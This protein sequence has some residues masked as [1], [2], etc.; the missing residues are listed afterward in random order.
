MGITPRSVSKQIKEMIDGVYSEKSGKDDLKKAHDAAE[1]E[2]MDWDN[3]EAL[4]AQCPLEHRPK[5]R[6]LSEFAQRHDSPVV[7]DPYYGSAK[8]FERVLDLIEDACDGLVAHLK[9]R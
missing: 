7:P 5:L 9:A 4:S 8:G 1:V 2:A 3:F 6:R